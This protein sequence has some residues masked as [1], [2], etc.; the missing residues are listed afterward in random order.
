[1]P[2]LNDLLS[3]PMIHT[4]RRDGAL[5]TAIRVPV[6]DLRLNRFGWMLYVSHSDD[7]TYQ[8]DIE[9]LMDRSGQRFPKVYK[10]DE[11]K[12]YAE[13]W[14]CSD[15]QLGYQDK[16]TEEESLS[17]I[18]GPQTKMIEDM[19]NDLQTLKAQVEALA[20]STQ[21]NFGKL[22]QS[23]NQ[24][25]T[26]VDDIAKERRQRKTANELLN[27]SIQSSTAEVAKR[28]SEHTMQ[29][30]SDQVELG[31]SYYQNV[32]LQS[33][34]SFD[35]ARLLTGIGAGVFVISILTLLIPVANGNTI[36]VASVGTIASTIV[37]VV[38]GLSFLYNKAS[39]QFARFHL[40]L[41]R[42]NRASIA[43]AMCGSVKDETKKQEI[44]ISIIQEIMK[45]EESLKG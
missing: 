40:F 10:L 38:A 9:T 23:Y 25:K 6:D 37:E 4:T 17:P 5:L 35:L 20:Q 42:T 12:A 18:K 19:H 27:K 45:N 7:S 28:T 3:S 14:E 16:A 32:A 1:V 13:K 11:L 31:S 44:I 43:H 15:W 21:D 8:D 29:I 22:T 39:E 26:Q 30:I 2:G 36:I 34:Q 41:D 24:V 33:K